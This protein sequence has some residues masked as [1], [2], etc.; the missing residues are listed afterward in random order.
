MSRS[1]AS[2]ITVACVL[3]AA[4]LIVQLV[5]MVRRNPGSWKPEQ[6]LIALGLLVT[7]IVAVVPQLFAD[8]GDSAAVTDYRERVRSA[9]SSMRATTNPLMD[10]MNAGGIDRDALASGLRNQVTAA[11]GVLDGLWAV[12]PP[13]ELAADVAAAH[14]SADT[15]FAAVNGHLDQMPSQYAA[16][17]TIQDVS[18][19]GGALDAGLRPL[20]A[21]FEAAMSELAGAGCAPPIAAATP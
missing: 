14:S 5:R 1:I 19:F 9:C 15:L 16:T 21:A 18:A 17:M 10:A 13:G 7:L 6:S 8:D 3:V 4:F 2:I 12:A 11:A 20:G